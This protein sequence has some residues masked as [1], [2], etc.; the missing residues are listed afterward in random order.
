MY[1]NVRVIPGI[2]LT[3][4]C[5]CFHGYFVCCLSIVIGSVHLHTESSYGNAKTDGKSVSV[6]RPLIIEIPLE[7]SINK[8]GK[9]L[10]D[11]YASIAD[12]MPITTVSGPV[13]ALPMANKLPLKTV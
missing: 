1:E 5:V 6:T 12:L 13:R 9:C 3:W 7:M 4:C 2:S 11:T 10:H 8:K